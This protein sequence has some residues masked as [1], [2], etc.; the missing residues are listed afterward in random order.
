M[1]QLPVK[2]EMLKFDLLKHE[3]ANQ[4][5]IV[6]VSETSLSDSYNVSNLLIS[7]FQ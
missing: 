6:T 1:E 3:I 7:G 2:N 4:F 5:H